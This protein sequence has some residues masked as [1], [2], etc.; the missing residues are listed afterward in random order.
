MGAPATKQ[1]LRFLDAWAQAEG[2]TASFNPFNT[3]QPFRGAGDYNRAGVKSYASPAAGIE[4]TKQT[5]LNGHYN[6]IVNLLRSGKA[7]A[8]QLAT[9]VANSPW[10]TGHG[11]LNVLGS[12]PVSY[13][14]AGPR[15]PKGGGAALTPTTGGLP[16]VQQALAA[17]LLGGNDPSQNPLVQSE[18]LLSMAM[19]RKQLGAAQQ[20]YGPTQVPTAKQNPDIPMHG[21]PGS[22]AGGFLPKQF[23][24]KPGRLDQGHDFQTNPGAPI[25]APGDGVV[26][27]V[28]S[29]P[30]GFGPAYPIVHFTSG[31]YA[32]RNVYIGHTLSQVRPGQRFSAGQVL[33]HTGTHPIGNASVPGWA[34]IGFAPNG[35]PGPDGQSTPF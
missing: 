2:G 16:Q 21:N 13:S 34:E 23:T 31:P 18:N 19:M 15:P 30:H 35:L 12:G 22:K 25:V 8:T 7:D 11:V 1:N 10:G 32:G 5:L 33:S 29:D 17:M 28:K 14:A 24:Y 6:D 26:V 20:V 4:A 3:T 27:S 9:A